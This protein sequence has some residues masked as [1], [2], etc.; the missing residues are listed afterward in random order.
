MR[1]PPLLCCAILAALL[2]LAA[3]GCALRPPGR[4]R[5]APTVVP[6]ERIEALV[7]A[8]MQE[9]IRWGLLDVR[10]DAGSPPCAVLSDGSCRG[11]ADGCGREQSAALCPLVN[12]YW[13]TLVEDGAEERHRCFAPDRCEAAWPDPFTVPEPTAPWSAAFVSALLRGVGFTPT[14]FRFSAAHARYVVAARDATA[15]AFELLPT[16]VVPAVGDLACA[17]RAAAIGR[18]TTPAA[19]RDGP[20]TTPMHCDLVVAVYPEARIAHAIGGNVQQAVA[21]SLITLDGAGRLDPALNP[22]RP[23]LLVLRPRRSLPV[24]PAP[25]DAALAP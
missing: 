23:W 2:L 15:S 10:I 19:V 14:E 8:A 21:R 12:G 1:R 13:R 24:M 5:V 22:A 18:V 11:V 9:W 17:T 7:Q 6:P 25:P 16:K 4:P 20:G 3:T